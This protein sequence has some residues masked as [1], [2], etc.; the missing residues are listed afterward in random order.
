MRRM[1]SVFLTMLLLGVSSFAS[2]QEFGDLEPQYEP[3]SRIS[4]RLVDDGFENVRVQRNGNCIKVALEDNHYRGI[5]R[6]L[7]RALQLISPSDQ[8]QDSIC[9]I[10]L[11]NRVPRLT[12]T[13]V[14]DKGTWSVD[15]RHGGVI[16]RGFARAKVRNSSAFKL[17]IVPYPT[18]I[19][20]NH[21]YDRLWSSA[22]YLSP[23]L[24]MGLWPGAKIVAQV[25]FLVYNAFVDEHYRNVVPG[26]VV[27]SQFFKP[28]S[29]WDITL[30]G[31]IF[32]VN[33]TGLDGRVDYHVN[34]NLDV[35]FIVGTTGPW[36]IGDKSLT[37]CYWDKFNAVARINYYEPHTNLQF[38]LKAGQFMFEDVGVRLDVLRH[39]RDYAVGV[40]GN[41]TTYNTNI[42]IQFSVPIGPKKMGKHRAVRLRMPETISFNFNENIDVYK[43]YSPDKMEQLYKTAPDQNYSAHYWQPDLIRDCILL[44]LEGE[45]E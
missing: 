20:S 14:H 41:A 3:V 8:T 25:R 27:F 4:Q 44:Y 34:N 9:L 22:M 19:F 40:F 32:N 23:T 6:G 35:G 37:L 42:G 17:D 1:L 24:E 39:F 43:S 11:D 31:G 2:A 33:R 29:D 13:A 38:D 30:S 16:T 36:Y 18:L 15:A 26:Y 10:A 5:F 45:I 28:S 21:R 7:A 12:V